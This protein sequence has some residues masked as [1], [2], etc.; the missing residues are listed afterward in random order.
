MLGVIVAHAD[1]GIDPR[2]RW[3][4]AAKGNVR[5]GWLAS[6]ASPMPDG[7]DLRS[8]I[9]A[10]SDDEQLLVG[11]D[12]PIGLPRAYADRAGVRSFL[13]LL[14]RLGQEEW[15]EFFSVADVAGEIAVNRPFY[16]RTA[17]RKGAKRQVH[18][19][20]ALGMSMSDLRRRCEHR[21]PD[22]SAACSLFWTV[23]G[24]QVGKGALAGWQMLQ[25]HPS[26]TIAY[27]PFEGPLDELIKSNQTVVAETYPAEF[28]GHLGLPRVI[29]KRRQASRAALAPRLCEVAGDLGIQLMPESRAQIDDGF[30]ATSHGEDAFDAFVGLVGMINVLSGRRPSGEPPDDQY[31]TSVEGWILGQHAVTHTVVGPMAM[32]LAV[33]PQSRD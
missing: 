15:A 26:N 3:V 30:G 21:Q 11:F 7:S 17:Q 18:L 10:C 14:P 29:G 22:R 13:D 6:P 9:Q 12:F 19:T 24:N 8:R 25:A 1:W 16:P 33:R 28:Y 4:A 2:K 23:G 32:P 27:W 31:V 5:D 20:T